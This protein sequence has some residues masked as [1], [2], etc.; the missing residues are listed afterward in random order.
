LFDSRGDFLAEV[1]RAW[2]FA[3]ALGILVIQFREI[4]WPPLARA[5]HLVAKYSYGIYVSH[6]AVFWV[7]ISPMSHFPT[8]VRVLTGAA[9]SV[10]APVALYHAVEHPCIRLGARYAERFRRAQNTRTVTPLTA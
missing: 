4:S 10:I 2:I 7:A 3:L 9:L 6:V 8:P 1:H 5:A